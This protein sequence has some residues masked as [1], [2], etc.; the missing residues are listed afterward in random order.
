MALP[1]LSSRLTLRALPPLPPPPPMLWARMPSDISPVVLILPL[2]VTNTFPPVLPF[3]PPPPTERFPLKLRP[4]LAAPKPIVAVKLDP[5]DPPPPPILCAKIPWESLS[6]V[7]IA[8]SLTTVTLPPVLPSPPEP[9]TL[10]LAL[11]FQVSFSPPKPVPTETLEPPLPPPPPMLWARMPWD[12]ICEY[13]SARIASDGS[14]GSGAGRLI[15]GRYVSRDSL[16][17][18]P[19]VRPVVALNRLHI[20]ST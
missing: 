6:R 15:C 11:T 10:M 16:R 3:P 14:C 7:V 1:A 17:Y 18:N 20:D 4:S 8:L 9:P 13:R 12:A 19:G 5:P 2:L